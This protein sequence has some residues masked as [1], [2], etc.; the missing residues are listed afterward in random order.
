MKIIF[1]SY[2]YWPPDFGGELLISIERFQS[3]AARGSQVTVLTSGRPGFARLEHYQGLDIWRS[4]TI[5]DSRPGRLLRRTIFFFW[6]CWQLL[7][8]P[9]EVLHVGSPGGI[10]PISSAVAAR[11]LSILARLKRARSFTVHSLADSE[12]SAF[13]SCGWQGF[14]RR[15]FFGSFD[16]VIAVSPVL[17]HG[18]SPH[19]PGRVALIP[20][21]FRDDIFI[22]RPETRRAFR[23]KKGV[24]TGDVTFVFLG[25]VGRRKGFDVLAQAFADLAVE[26]SDWRLWVIGPHSVTENQNIDESEVADVTRALKAAEKQVTF[27]GR[28]DERASLSRILSAGDVFVF[29]SRKEGMGIAPMEAMA[30]GLPVIIARIPGVT[31]LANI[32]GD[33]G[34]YVPPGDLPALKAAML[35]LGTDE[36]LRKRMGACAAQVVR[37]GF[38]WEP[39][40][41]KWM[42]LY[43]G[44]AATERTSPEPAQHA[45]DFQRKDAKV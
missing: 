42:K 44:S 34:L 10:G 31:D 13:E 25:S 21:G 43:D 37:E 14:W 30:V 32:E 36:E 16:C 28:V 29:P 12:T 27:W 17:Y 19:F 23:A 35:R 6:T 22:S 45:E 9:F 11:I 1:V 3:L 5:H 4:A 41:T 7:R 8:K 40:V 24:R 2:Q 18:L 38:A 15:I 20:C 26:H 39:H 33:T